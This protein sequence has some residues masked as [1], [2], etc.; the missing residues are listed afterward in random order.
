MYIIEHREN[1]VVSCLPDFISKRSLIEVTAVGQRFA[2]Y[3]D[4]NG[5]RNYDSKYYYE[6]MLEE[7]PK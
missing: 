6:L 4:M 5:G 7:E 3:M 1:G 2:Q